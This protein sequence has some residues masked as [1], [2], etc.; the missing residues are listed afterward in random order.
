[1]ARP[2]FA[3]RAT[4]IVVGVAYAVALYVSGVH[5]QDGAKKVLSY[6]P[7]LA[8][9]L[10][11]AWDL[12]LWRLPGV[13]HLSRRPLLR[14]TWRTTLTPTEESHIPEGGNRGPIEAYIVIH[15]T[16]WSIDVRQYTAESRSDSRASL[17]SNS[18]SQAFRSLTYTYANQP[19]RGLE[20]RSQFHLG[21]AALDIVGMRPSLISGDYFTDRYTKGDMRLE[22]VDRT[23]NHPDFSAA[24]THCQPAE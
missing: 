22:L 3:V 16:Y 14:G 1:M 7:T 10:L 19:H 20:R 18:G 12:W 24:R 4:A 21:T 17:W 23:T 5:L 8:T 13:Q 6:L 9:L 11:A 2:A 15:Q